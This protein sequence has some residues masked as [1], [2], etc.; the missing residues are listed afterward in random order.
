MHR[1]QATAILVFILLLCVSGPAGA[2][3]NRA[4]DRQG[5]TLTIE[6]LTPSANHNPTDVRIA[7]LSALFVA[8]GENPSSFTPAGPFKATFEGQISVR[9]RTYVRFSAQGRG[10]LIL[11]VGGK[12]V[13]DVAGEDLSKLTS[14]EVRLGKGKNQIVATYEGPP[15]GDAQVR[16]FWSSKTWSPEPVPPS[17]FSCSISDPATAESLQIR[18]GRSLVGQ[19]RC[20]KCHASPG[21]GQQAMPELTMDAPSFTDIGARLNQSWLAAWIHDPRSLRP[22]AQMPRL[23]HENRPD[24]RAADIAAYLASLGKTTAISDVGG[25]VLD[26]GRVFANLDC[27]ACHTAPGAK[28]D[29]TRISLDHVSAKFKKLGLEDYLLKPEAHFAWNPMPNFHLSPQEASDLSAY[30]TSIDQNLP[31]SAGDAAKGKQWVE[32]MGCLNCHT[33]E[34]RESTATFP[35]LASITNDK[36]ATGCLAADEAHRG[37]APEFALSEEQQEAIVAFLQSDRA[38]LNI[39]AA[40]EFAERQIHTMRCLACHAR[41]GDESLIA[42]QLSDESQA[43]HAKFPNPP[44][45][46]HE[47]LAADQRPPMLTWAGEKL[48]PD[49]MAQFIGGQILY[50]PRYYLRARM[51]SFPARAQDIAFGLA[52]EHGCAPALPP[53]PAPDAKLA[54]IGRQLCGKTPNQGFSCVQCHAAAS[55][56]PFAAFEAPAINLKYISQRLRLDYYNRWIRDPQRI[57]PTTKMPKF[58]DDE[59]KTGL[60]A[61]DNDGQKQFDA[62]WQYLL[63]GE[64]LKPPT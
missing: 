6:P 37:S 45:G 47:L 34:G 17:V 33:L 29:P 22:D 58:E 19:F 18:E 43:L 38:S 49:W 31:R 42:Q 12:Q 35:T 41:D 24:P 27:I 9:L 60:P 56:P 2:E 1:A 36:L 16:L 8:I 3:E 15:T 32:S 13:L 21:I 7:R 25:N 10:H 5:L 4:K 20:L 61:F 30:L 63:G 44:A 46:E 57:D 11:K 26:G 54:E 55:Q 50:K 51:P 52:E 59:G 14:D 53:E 28:P 39:D 23:F 40:P 64:R 62:I 48:R